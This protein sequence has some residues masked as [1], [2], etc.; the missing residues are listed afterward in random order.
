[1]LASTEEDSLRVRTNVRGEEGYLYRV[2]M[3]DGAARKLFLSYVDTATRLT[4]RPR[5]YNTLTGNCTTIVYRLAD[6][7]VP[8]LPLDYRVLFSGYLPEYLYR[9][10]A[11]VGADSP[12]AYRQ[13]GH[14][15]QRAR[16][17]V[18]AAEFSRNIRRGVPGVP[19]TPVPAQDGEAMP[20]AGARSRAT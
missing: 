9:L 15:T 17:T 4:D 18:D 5:F 1:V 19:Q 10:D 2:H 20:G 6:Q 3:P 14:Y 12:L 13:A 7:I 11:L 8:G 16:A